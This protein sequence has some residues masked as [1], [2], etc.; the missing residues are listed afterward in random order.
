M[1]GWLVGLAAWT[2]CQGAASDEGASASDGATDGAPDG[3]PVGPI[4]SRCADP[5]PDAPVVPRV[6]PELSSFEGADLQVYLPEGLRGVVFYF[7]GGDELNEWNGDEQTA[8]SNQM[9]DA[10]I[11]WIVYT[12]ANTGRGESWDNDDT[13]FATNAD[14]GR[15]ERLWT[16]LVATTP[17]EADTPIVSVGFSDGA[18][19]SVFFA[20]E[21]QRQLGWPISSVLVHNSSAGGVDLPDAPMWVTASD[22]DDAG[23][24]SGAEQLSEEQAERGFRSA[25]RRVSER[26]ITPEVFL[27]HAEW[28]LTKASE[29]HADM[30]GFGLVDADGTRLVEP[31]D[32]ERAVAA[33]SEQSLERAVEVA[34]ART[35][36]VWATHRYSA[37]YT[38]E[39]C[40]FVLETLG[41]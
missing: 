8:F 19:F 37:V 38:Q 35:R 3:P 22:F 40:A 14:L 25:F 6:L 16:E 34:A 13:D 20:A 11:G 1:K 30:V 27:R 10:G 36:V 28:D 2:G 21:T 12:K 15:L 5:G 33:W 31:S 4:T 17:L 23:V 26:P 24:L 7:Y 39:E 18:A 32:I 29:M 41:F 9:F